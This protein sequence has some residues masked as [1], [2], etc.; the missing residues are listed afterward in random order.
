MPMASSHTPDNLTIRPRNMAFGRGEKSVRWWHNGDPVATAF[1]NA[2]SL[3]F[4]QGESFFIESVRVFRDEAPADLKEQIS[5]FV[6]QEVFHTREHVAFN[7]QVTAAGYDTRA[8]DARVRERLDIARSRPPLSQL[9]V[10]M[11]L[12]HFTA[13][14]AHALLAD[15]RHLEGAPESIRKLWQWHAMEEIEHKGVAFDTYIHASR[16]LARHKRWL[17]RSIVMLYVTYHFVRGRILDMADLFRQD[18]IN[19]AATWLRLIRFLVVRPG[20]GRAVLTDWFAFFRPGFHPWDIDDRE[21][22]AKAEREL[23]APAAAA[24]SIS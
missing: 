20:I 1:Y 19:K 8:I 16:H 24:D 12:E 9:A 4:P 2:L 23:S 18:G 15:P 3:T 14:L 5:A 6:K 13:I 21:L 11:A 10:T 7:R 22:L 17:L